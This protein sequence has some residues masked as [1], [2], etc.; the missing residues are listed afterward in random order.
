M[1]Y[2][3]QQR[4]QPLSPGGGFAGGV[5][6][7][8]ADIFLGYGSFAPATFIVKGIEG[9]IVGYLYFRWKQEKS[10]NNNLIPKLISIPLG[11][12]VMVLGYF[13]YEIILLGLGDALVEFPWN[14]LQ[15]IVGLTATISLTSILE[16]QL[17]LEILR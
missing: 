16:T 8:L 6:S 1:I 10:K 17:Q 15:V 14:L 2:Q 12:L 9:F 11:G 13:I 7:A 4:R 5:G 3:A